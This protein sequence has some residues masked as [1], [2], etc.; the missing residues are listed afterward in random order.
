VTAQADSSALFESPTELFLAGRWTN[1]ER[2]AFP[3]EDPALGSTLCDGADAGPGDARNALD[4]AADVQ[5]RW[6]ATPSRV[7]S[8]I[9]RNAFD[10]VHERADRLAL[11]ITLESGKPL[12][13]ARAEIDY[14]ADFLRWY[15]EEA[16]RPAGGY[17]A[18]PGGDKR[19]LT[20]THPVGPCLLITP[21]N[22]PLAM[23]TRKLG[24]ALAAGCTAIVK[25]AA[26][27]PLTALA[28]AEIVEACGLP[29]GVLS[30]LPTSDAGA[31]V[32]PLLG[33]RRLRKL[34]FT[35][36]TEVGRLLAEQAAPNLL[37]VSMELGGNA[38]FLV[39][40]DADLDRAVDAA[41]LAKL[42]NT[43]QSCTAA[44]RFLVHER[45]SERFSVRLAE[46]LAEAK[47]GPGTNEAVEVGPLIDATARKRVESLVE[48]AV[49]G[50]AELLCGGEAP[51]R[52]GYF[53]RPTLLG[54]VPADA[55][56]ARS[57]IFAPVAPVSTFASEEEALR[58]ANDTD[59]GLVAFVHTSD[60]DR[61]LRIGDR[62][63]V[64]MV[65]MNRGM[66]SE[67]SAPFG[68]VKQSGLGRE[69]GAE[70]LREY[71]ETRYM[72]VTA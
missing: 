2:G 3:V 70:G 33:D 5:D 58:K 40:E 22:F 56:I 68:G 12:A 53:Y 51:D 43:G 32:A 42:R 55:P 1:G 59:W 63:Q 24:P 46:R 62:L 48:A 67:A 35:G 39:F 14:G 29:A 54:T 50:G 72:A 10:L 17:R 37:R 64:G 23:V 21:W 66:V 41:V 18:A 16:V 57:E 31:V 47:V 15:A 69:G 20:S 45:V 28:L 49:A 52:P 4:A 8:E 38:P 30:V 36:S 19:I 7:R 61:A 13:E 6:A 34:S 26:E 60:L 9:L 65:G 11:L 25:P 27:T 44:N 71:Q